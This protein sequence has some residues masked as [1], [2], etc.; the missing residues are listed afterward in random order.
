MFTDYYDRSAKVA[1]LQRAQH[2]PGF[3][4]VEADL[5]ADELDSHLEGADLI[6]HLA[7]QPGVRDSWGRGFEVYV[8]HNVLATQRVLDAAVRTGIERVVYASSSSIYGAAESLPTAEDVTPLP[9]L[10]LRRH[11]ADRRE[12]AGRVPPAGHLQRLAALLHGLR[13]PSA[14]RHGHPPLHLGGHDRRPGAPLR[15]GHPGS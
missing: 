11:Q 6:V 7:A 4:L 12:P 14:P 13:T 2:P 1:N 15:H 10:P 8:G 9:D 5:R 3:R